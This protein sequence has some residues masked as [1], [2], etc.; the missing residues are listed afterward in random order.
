M[1]LEPDYGE[2]LLNYEEAEALTPEARKL[3]G[4]PIRKADLYDLE[5]RIQVEVADEWW[6]NLLNFNVPM[7]DLLDDH[8]V[9]DLHRRLYAP[10]WEWGG[11]Q[12]RRETNI[13]IAPEHIAVE[14]RN[15]LDDL[16]Y[17]WKHQTGMDARMLGIA[18]HAALVRIHPF[19]DGNGRVT[20]LLAELVYL[21][22]QTAWEPV[23][24]YDWEV[25]RATYIRLRREYD[26]T[27]DP[28]ALAEFITVINLEATE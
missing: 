7:R 21:A 16:N 2:T 12:R 3:L 11:R 18:A 8:F 27:R 17:H 5:Q 20:R 25:D 13:G 26:V 28:R 14:M 9:R 15:A 1:A 19:V 22:G 24:T 23:H 10:V 6:G 4:N